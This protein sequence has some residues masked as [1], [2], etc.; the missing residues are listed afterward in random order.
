MV[1][2]VENAFDGED[3]GTE[4]PDF[5]TGSSNWDQEMAEG[6]AL[7]VAKVFHAANCPEIVVSPEVENQV[8]ADMIAKAA[9]RCKYKAYS[10]NTEHK[11]PIGVAIFTS[12]RV[13]STGL[14][15]TGYRPHLRVDFDDGL[16]LIGVHFKSQRDGGEDKRLMAAQAIKKEIARKSARRLIAAGDFNTED[17]LLAGTGLTNCTRSAKPTHVFRGEWHQLDKIYATHCGDALRLD[18]PFLFKDDNTPFRS[19]MRK[20]GGQTTHRNEGY[21]DHIPLVMMK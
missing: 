19:V 12:K 3:Q 18:V 10:A 4:Y 16:S 14:V 8:A 11:F 13:V 7:R 15:D 1:A 21:S 2:N 20:D 17:D 9:I 5:K 6:K